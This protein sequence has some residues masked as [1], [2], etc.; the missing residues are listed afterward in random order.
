MK[1]NPSILKQVIHG[2]EIHVQPL[3]ATPLVEVIGYERVLIENHVSIASYDTQQI[4]IRVKYGMIRIQ[5]DALKLAY[6]SKEK[7]VITGKVG[8]IHLLN[9]NSL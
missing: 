8:S 6:M 2:S 1:K 5:G 9:S 4:Y 3:S 7:L